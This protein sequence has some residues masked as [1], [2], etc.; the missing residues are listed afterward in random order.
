M[1]DGQRG[2]HEGAAKLPGEDV[3]AADDRTRTQY[4]VEDK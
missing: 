2:Q 4:I 3:Q 1:K